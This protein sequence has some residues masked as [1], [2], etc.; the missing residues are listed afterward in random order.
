MGYATNRA[1]LEITPLT[2][3]SVRALIAAAVFSGVDVSSR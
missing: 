1:S 3:V 2:A